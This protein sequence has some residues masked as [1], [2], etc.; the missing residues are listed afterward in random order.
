MS[1]D[2]KLKQLY[3]GILDKWLADDTAID[4]QILRD[5]NS[6][7]LSVKSN[8]HK[9][10]LLALQKKLANKYPN[11]LEHNTNQLDFPE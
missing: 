3:S 1:L 10:K 11:I 5:I 8:L 6:Y 2:K 9:T 4:Q 7:I